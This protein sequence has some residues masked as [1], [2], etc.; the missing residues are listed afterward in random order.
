MIEEE[1][2]LQKA[3]ELKIEV[4]DADITPHVDR[5]IKR[6]AVATSRP[7]RSSAPR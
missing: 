6:R 2:L 4:P 1:L 7:R 5:Q 3:K